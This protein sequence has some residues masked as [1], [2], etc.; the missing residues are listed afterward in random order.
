[1]KLAVVALDY[2]GTITDADGTLNG[3][4]R[5]A[6]QE[7]RSRGIAVLIVTGRRLEHLREDVGDL[8]IVDAV[9]AE[10][11]ALIA[12]PSSGRTLSL[13]HPPPQVL[14]DELKRLQVVFQTGECVIELE[15]AHGPAA[16]DAIR[17]LE[18][19]LVLEFN[20]D[21][22]MLLPQS[23]SKGIGLSEALTAL[24]LSV[25]NTVAIGNAEN[26][27][28]MLAIAEIGA[29]VQWGSVVLQRAADE[30]VEGTGASAVAV[31]IREVADRA[32][33][34]SNGAGRRTLL[35]G[36]EASGKLVT[37]NLRGRNVLVAGDP[38]SGKSWIAG[39]LTEQLIIQHYSVCIID[40]EGDYRGLETLPGVI[41]FGGDDPPPR[42][43]ELMQA[44]R[45][46]D[47]STVIDL[48]KLPFDQKREYVPQ[49]LNM[50]NTVRRQTGLPHRI[51]LDEAHYFLN[52]D[53]VAG[54]L[55]AELAGYTLV[56]YRLSELPASVIDAHDVVLLTRHTDRHEI[57]ALRA[58]RPSADPNVDWTAS[59]SGLRLEDAV[60]L[61]GGEDGPDHPQKFQIA[62]RITFHVRHQHKYLDV[63]VSNQHAFVFRKNGEVVGRARSFR[64]LSEVLASVG[65]HVLGEYLRRSDLSRWIRDVFGD[66]PLAAQ[67]REV[68]RRYALQATSDVNDEL[69]RLIRERY[70]CDDEP[71]APYSSRLHSM[72]EPS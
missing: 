66:R 42:P 60:L 48:S 43:R 37:L 55:D 1:M 35:L 4:V 6:I 47:F 25:H 13:G 38:R 24:R 67:V 19:P 18:L 39:L 12:F 26:D 27:H 5:A 36:R 52:A 20:R 32:R 29:A 40:P 57:E 34:T 9:V 22:L 10:N 45:N 64:E 61:P 65:G 68:E 21:R 23:V 72:Y 46:A 15:A 7:L 54:L 11:G 17:R 3:D 63:P 14:L 31:Y 59:L 44:L 28:E 56:T 50:L 2:D 8:R 41:L 33:L 51:V 62:P 71:L 16:L 30:I 53:N 70:S 69:L 58:L 49:L